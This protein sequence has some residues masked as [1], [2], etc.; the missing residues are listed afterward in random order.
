MKDTRRQFLKKS[1]A[2]AGSVWVAPIV[3]AAPA[4]IYKAAVIGRTGGGDY[5]HGLDTIFNGLENVKVVAVADENPD[6][7]KQAVSRAGAD[8]GYADYHE[9]LKKERP[10]LV[11]IAPRQPDCHKDM[12]LA[13]IEVGAHLY[14]EKPFTETPAEADEILTA[15]SA[16]GLKI[17]VA[18]TKR[19]M[20]HF[21]VIRNLLREKYLGDVLEVRFQGKQDSR[22]GGEDLYVLGVHDM[23]MMRFWFGDPLWCFAG[24]TQEGLDISTEDIHR[25]QEPYLVAGDTI[26]ADYQFNHNIHVGW[27]SV[28]APG[29]NSNLKIQDKTVTKWGFEIFGTKRVLSHQESV[30]TFILDSP[31]LVT[32]DPNVKWKPL[33]DVATLAPNERPGHPIRNLIHAIE[34]NDSPMCSG[35][36]ARWAVEMVCAIYLA[37]RA[38]SRI[39][40]PL[41]VRENPLLNF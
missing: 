14:M 32:G 6:G 5:G 13:A 25:G 24:V 39:S 22:V 1:A 12:A 26:H 16:K 31:F 9:M 15:A 38:R 40:F 11:S 3:L 29:W 30:G 41:D 36:D 23:D 10:E 21:L 17:A 33:S 2:A 18:H 8:R 28:K 4:K 34:T 7:L 20:D 19:F 37:Q 27:M 35:E